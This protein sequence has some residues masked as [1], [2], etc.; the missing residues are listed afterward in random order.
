LNINVID[1][2]KVYLMKCKILFSIAVV[3]GLVS[4]QVSA[5]NAN[6]G[7]YNLILKGELT[8]DSDIEGRIFVGS[9]DVANILDVGSRLA[10][11]PTVDAVTVVGDIAA[12][13]VRALNGNIVYGGAIGSTT[14]TTN[15]PLSTISNPSQSTLQANFD[16]LWATVEA[17]S[18]Y[19]ASLDETGILNSTDKN[20]MKFENDN[21]L[22]LNV[23]NIDTTNLN[24]N[25]GLG[26]DVDP[27][28]PVVINV[29]G[30]GTINITSKA[31]G[32]MATATAA[33]NIIWNFF[34]AN[35]I[36]FSNGSWYGSVLAPNATINSTGGNIEGGVAALSLDINGEL[37][38]SLYT[39]TPPTPPSEVP[40]PAGL[41]IIGLGLLLIARRKRAN[42]V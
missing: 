11:D 1:H 14:L 29:S 17:D 33:T 34:E 10:A 2:L 41:A 22:N 13:K 15:N 21:S 32:N 38:N 42:K 18:A 39:Y 4:S 20:N 27:T 40:A 8:A 6:V 25:G 16:T 23:F 5:T 24:S 35:V 9:I 28:A 26:F 7:T 31:L 12:N 19:F 3:L 37:H 30:T 36:N